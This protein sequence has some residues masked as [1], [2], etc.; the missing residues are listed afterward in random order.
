[1]KTKLTKEQRKELA[2]KKFL[3]VIEPAQKKYREVQEPA[4]KKYR[5]VIEPAEKKYLEE[6]NKIDEEKTK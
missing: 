5:E 2:E 3:K 4:L 1:M 6:W